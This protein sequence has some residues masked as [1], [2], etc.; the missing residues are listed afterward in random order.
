MPG[1]IG[2][3]KVIR[4]LGEGSTCKVKLAL[5]ETNGQKVAIK[6]MNSNLDEKMREL[7]MVEV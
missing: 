2:K 3:Y 1:K 6:M 7:I 4:T 5:D